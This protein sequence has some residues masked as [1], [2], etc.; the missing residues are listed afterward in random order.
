MLAWASDLKGYRIDKV[1]MYFSG[2][3]TGIT[4]TRT[5]P[6]VGI[7]TFDADIG[8]GAPPGQYLLELKAFNEANDQST[9]WPYLSI[10]SGEEEAYTTYSLP[11][12]DTIDDWRLL[13]R[14]LI[15]GYSKGSGIPAVALGGYYFTEIYEL[16]GGTFTLLAYITDADGCS[17]VKEVRVLF[18]QMDTG[19]RLLDNGMNND[20]GAGDCVF[21]LKIDLPAGGLEGTAGTYLLE[22]E[23]VDHS[24][25][26]SLIWPYLTIVQ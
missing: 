14:M 26:S 18:G 7:F 24:G 20:F 19:L 9:L 3:P 11:A 1:D 22:L 5:D 10:L 12:E 6:V 15:H 8:S 13:S 16:T 17:D 21:G 23:A 4:L 2:A 25:N